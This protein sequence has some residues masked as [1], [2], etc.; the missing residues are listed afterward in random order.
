MFFGLSIAL[1]SNFPFLASA[2]SAPIATELRGVWLTN[3]D[4]DVLFS[5]AN[6]H[7]AI[8]ESL[9]KAKLKKKS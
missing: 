4:S 9:L 5:R 7:R 8:Q 2:Q 1:A 3:V 6:L